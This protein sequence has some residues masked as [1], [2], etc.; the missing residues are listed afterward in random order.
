MG[1]EGL[2]LHEPAVPVGVGLDEFKTRI[3]D[4]GLRVVGLVGKISAIDLVL[5]AGFRVRILAGFSPG[6]GTLPFQASPSWPRKS[7]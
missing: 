7:S 3:E 1:I 2:D 6:A 5:A 4:P